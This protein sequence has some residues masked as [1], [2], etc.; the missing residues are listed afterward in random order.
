MT[1]VKEQECK[2]DLQKYIYSCKESR[3]NKKKR[4]DMNKHSLQNNEKKKL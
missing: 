2:N 3:Q 1:R 4:Q